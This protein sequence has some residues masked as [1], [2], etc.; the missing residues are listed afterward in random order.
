[1]ELGGVLLANM[2]EGWLDGNPNF[3]ATAEATDEPQ[4]Y[5]IITGADLPTFIYASR[6]L[7][8]YAIIRRARSAS[9]HCERRRWNWAGAN[10]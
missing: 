5:E 2:L 8:R 9:M 4:D 3:S 6:R 1:M 7:V 10:P